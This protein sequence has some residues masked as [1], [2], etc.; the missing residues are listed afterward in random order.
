MPPTSP[1]V[2]AYSRDTRDRYYIG[3]VIITFTG[4]ADDKHDGVPDLFTGYVFAETGE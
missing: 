1:D 4:V 2:E 3:V